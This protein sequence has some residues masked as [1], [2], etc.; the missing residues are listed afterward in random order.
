MIDLVTGVRSVRAEMNVPPSAKIALVLKG[1]TRRRAQRLERNRD[2]I[3][4]AGAAVERATSPTSFP[5]AR[6]NSWS[7]KR[8]RRCRWAT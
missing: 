3:A 5:K 8:W 1:A 2:V 6:R 7:E 4:D